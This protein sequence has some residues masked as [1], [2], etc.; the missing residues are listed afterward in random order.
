METLLG[1]NPL[2]EP[3]Y[4]ALEVPRDK[5]QAKRKA[6]SSND[7]AAIGS[8]VRWNKKDYGAGCNPGNSGGR[9]RNFGSS[10]VDRNAAKSSKSCLFRPNGFK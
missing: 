7:K 1:N 4:Q 2:E 6:A 3:W 9:T 10:K 5:H 8:A